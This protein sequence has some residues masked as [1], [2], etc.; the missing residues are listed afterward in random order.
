MKHQARRQHYV[1]KCL[2]RNFIAQEN[3]NLYRFDK[4]NNKVIQTDIG[5]LF[6]K[7]DFYTI[8]NNTEVED[9]YSNTIESKT[10]PIIKDIVR[11]LSLKH[12]PTKEFGNLLIFLMAQD[13]RSIR[14][15]TAISNLLTQI[16]RH[17]DQI[18]KETGQWPT[19]RY[20]NSVTSHNF[21]SNELKRKQAKLI[22]ENQAAGLQA[23]MH[24]KAMYLLYAKDK[25]DMFYIGDSPVTMYQSRNIPNCGTY[26]YAAPYIEIYLPISP[27]ITLALLDTNLHTARI[28]PHL[29]TLLI[30]HK[31]VKFLNQLQVAWA[32]RYVAS[33]RNNFNQAVNFL[34]SFPYYRSHQEGTNIQS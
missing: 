31:K 27:K 29:S 30:D 28:Q 10:A 33:S 6:V 25:G 16:N 11:N 12:L 20:G 1:P 4:R 9:F 5:N 19:D 8:D 17:I 26:G 23:L 18:Y 24:N 15:K 2:L 32:N 13:V 14:M 21:D 3:Q 7:R 34:N 22:V